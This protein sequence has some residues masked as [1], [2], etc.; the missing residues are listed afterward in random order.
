MLLLLFFA[1]GYDMVSEY[2]HGRSFSLQQR[3]K[4]VI[5]ANSMKDQEKNVEDLRSLDHVDVSR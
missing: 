3:P 4:S 2:H 1:A 5:K